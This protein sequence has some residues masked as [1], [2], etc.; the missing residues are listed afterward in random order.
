MR[1][2]QLLV[3]RLPEYSRS[4]LQ[5]W[6]RDGKVW[7]DGQPCKPK[8]RLRGGEQIRVAVVLDPRVESLPQAIPLRILYE[9]EALLVVDK[10]P[11]LVVHPAAGNPDGTLLNALLHHDPQLARLP[12][13]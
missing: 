9:D 1:L 8:Q 4:R 11:D 3:E 13:A 12:R 6:I 5:Q 7:L 2:D 10:P